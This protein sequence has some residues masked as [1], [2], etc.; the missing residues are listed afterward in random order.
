M[1]RVKTIAVLLTCFNRIKKTNECLSSFISA[2]E[3]IPNYKFDIYLVDDNS[4]D[5]TAQLIRERYPIVRIIEGS[6]SLFWAGGMRLAWE[7]ALKSGIDYLGYLLIN[8][9]VSFVPT[10]WDNIIQTNKFAETNYKKCGIYVSSTMDKELGKYT[11]GGHK[12][13]RMIFKHVFYLIHPSNVPQEC[14]IANA[15]ILFVAKNVIDQIGI[16]DSHFTHSLADFDYTLTAHENG[17]PVL[18]C[19]GFGGYCVN[20]HFENK[21]QRSLV[22]R[23]NR[24]YDIKGLAL[25]EYLYYLKKHFWWKA[26]YAFLVHWLKALSPVFK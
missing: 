10:F 26:P 14:Q 19:P 15:N 21:V 6:G 3:S 22:E 1:D 8:D 17:F 25:N 5:G 13:K 18:V 4:Q 9:D 16:L 12:F 7:T 20:D 11:Y 2:I 23:I 24:L